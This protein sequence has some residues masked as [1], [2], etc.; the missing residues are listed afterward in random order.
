[1]VIVNA[2]PWLR[3]V[4]GLIAGCWV[5]VLIGCGVALLFAGRRLR[6]LE[7]ANLLL[8]VKLRAQE[9]ARRPAA[10]RAGPLLVVPPGKASRPASSPPGRVANSGR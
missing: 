2:H 9:K 8:R 5:G 3:F 4:A 1:M 10:S 6:Q 7:T